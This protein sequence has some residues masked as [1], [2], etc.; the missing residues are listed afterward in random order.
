MAESWLPLPDSLRAGLLNEPPPFILP[1]MSKLA[2]MTSICPEWPLTTILEVM[3]RHGYEGLEPRLGWPNQAG[4]VPELSKAKRQEISARFQDRGK[5][6]CC[7]ATGARFALADPASIKDQVEETRNAIEMAADLGAPLVRIFG[8][9]HGEGELTAIAHRTAEALR[10]VLDFADDH[11]I[12]L[13]FET[14]DFWCHSPLVR[15][16]IQLANHPRLGVL[17]DFMHTQR[18]FETPEESAA[19]IGPLTVHAHVHDSR[20]PPPEYKLTRCP[21]GQGDLDHEVPIQKLKQAGYQGYYS[22]EI[23]HRKGSTH[24]PEPVLAQHAEALRE[25]LARA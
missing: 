17:W 6:I 25:L 21:M 10:P 15:K 2:F 3:D 13:A 7:L 1:A 9:D 16:I 5:S 4:L 8:G 14:H 22:V 19:I 23:I 11:G 12:T 18:V 24:D 20:L